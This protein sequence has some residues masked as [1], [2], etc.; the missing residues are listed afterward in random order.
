MQATIRWL[1]EV[2]FEAASGSGHHIVLDG[3]SEHGGRNSGI[4]PM[5]AMLIGLG[6]CSAF[7]VVTML[8]KGR[9]AITECVVELEANRADSIPSVFTDITMKYV[10][11]GRRVSTSRVARA[12]ELSSQKYCSASAMLREAGVRL[13][14]TF[15][16]RESG[17][18]RNPR[19]YKRV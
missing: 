4:R 19:G 6:G 9:Q 7:D 17:D 2:A 12:V 5:E 10:V 3:A 16:V 11:T 18:D 8:R 13:T 15:E 14:H 1:D